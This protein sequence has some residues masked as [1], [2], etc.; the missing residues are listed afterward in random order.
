LARLVMRDPTRRILKRRLAALC[1]PAC[2]TAYLALHH[3]D[4]AREKRRRRV[5]DRVRRALAE[6]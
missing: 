4:R 1:H 6:V 5:M 2:R 3:R